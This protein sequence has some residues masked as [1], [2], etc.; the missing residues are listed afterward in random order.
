MRTD[1]DE[2]IR[3]VKSTP[4]IDHTGQTLGMLSVHYRKPCPHIDSD[5]TRLQILA[6][7][8]A[9]SIERRS[10]LRLLKS[11]EEETA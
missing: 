7:A 8:I 4:L 6:N 10:L 9:A 2:G 3:A 11:S 1:L 5:L